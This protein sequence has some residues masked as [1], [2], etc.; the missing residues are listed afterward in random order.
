MGRKNLNTMEEAFSY[1]IQYHLKRNGIEVY[2]YKELFLSSH[3]KLIIAK[4]TWITTGETE[5]D[6]DGITDGFLYKGTPY[7][8]I[9]LNDKLKKEG[10][11]NALTHEL[12]HFVSMESASHYFSENKNVE[13]LYAYRFGHILSKIF[14]NVSFKDSE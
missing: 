7:F 9:L 13:E 4:G 14:N 8:A 1:F 12:I 5:N 10:F 11:I 6:F 3:L 2:K